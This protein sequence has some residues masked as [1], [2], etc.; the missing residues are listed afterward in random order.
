MYFHVH[1]YTTES[2]DQRGNFIVPLLHVCVLM[3]HVI[4]LWVDSEVGYGVEL[5]HL[6]IVIPHHQ[7][8]IYGL[9]E[10]DDVMLITIVECVLRPLQLGV[11]AMELMLI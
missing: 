3:A 4:G 11:W 10:R 2:L 7:I 1:V 5:S 9:Y 8:T 6:L